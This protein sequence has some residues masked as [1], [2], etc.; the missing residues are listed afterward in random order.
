M[1][2]SETNQYAGEEEEAGQPVD[3]TE[4]RFEDLESG[5]RMVL[6]LAGWIAHE[7]R[8]LM[9]YV[10]DLV[11]RLDSYEGWTLP[12]GK[13]ELL[14]GTGS[15]PAFVE[16]SGDGLYRFRRA[17]ETGEAARCLVREHQEQIPVLLEEMLL[18]LGEWMEEERVDELSEEE[19]RCLLKHFDQFINRTSPT[20]FSDGP[21]AAAY[22]RLFVRAVEL[23]GELFGEDHP[24]LGPMLS[25]LGSHY[26][27]R[28]DENRARDVYES[29]LTVLEP[30]HA[31]YIPVLNN[32]ASLCSE[33]GD[34]QRAIEL[35]RDCLDEMNRSDPRY[36][37]VR[38]NLLRVRKR[39]TRMDEFLNLWF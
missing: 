27:T 12:A 15:L 38:E 37:R 31:E 5:P 32:L 29:S 3:S 30:D 8:F 33:H 6:G 9:P 26:R 22:E 7:D 17:A 16:S 39:L 28:G 19:T 20:A 13:T 35:Y 23:H 34:H 4:S 25:T 1:E 18:S 11:N 36:K 14:E 10:M 24:D 2:R 21:G